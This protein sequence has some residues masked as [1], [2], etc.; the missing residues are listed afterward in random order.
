MTQE[1]HFKRLNA[2]TEILVEALGSI[3]DQHSIDPRLLAGEVLLAV[4]QAVPCESRAWHASMV[5]QLGNNVATLSQW[6]EQLMNE[7][8]R[9][10]RIV[11]EAG[12]NEPTE[13]R[14]A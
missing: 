11:E 5:G 2:G 3:L 1:E 14:A 10:E 6:Y 9:L 12:L 4:E 13:N 7:A 8:E